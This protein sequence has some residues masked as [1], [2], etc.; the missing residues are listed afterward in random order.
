MLASNGYFPLVTL[1]TRV[2]AV[3]SSI[4]DYLITNDHKNIISPGMIKTDL[5]DHYS[6]FC[7]IDVVTCSN[8]TNQ[9]IFKCDFLKFKAEDFCD[10]LHNVQATFFQRNQDIYDNNFNHFFVTSLKL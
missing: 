4:I 7:F 6:I 5:I 9:K 10:D 2:T 3:A 8:K 1:P